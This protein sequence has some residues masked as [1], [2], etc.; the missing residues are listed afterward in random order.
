[1]A[2]SDDSPISD[3]RLVEILSELV[4]LR[5]TNERLVERIDELTERL[6]EQT[7]RIAELERENE[8]LRRTSKRPA[9]PFRRRDT[10]KKPKSQHKK[11]GR[12]SGHTGAS[13]ATPAPDEV[14]REHEVELSSCPCCGADELKNPH[15]LVQYVEDI[16]VRRVVH[17]ITTYSG[18]CE[19]C[20]RVRS[21]HPLQVSD[22]TGAA[23]VAVGPRAL[24]FALDLNKRLGLST[25]KT[26]EVLDQHLG[27]SLTAGGL[28][29]ASHRLAD[30]LEP[31]YE[32]LIDE[33]RDS[34]AVYVDETSWW[35]GEAGWWLWAFTDDEDTTVYSVEPRRNQKVV[36]EILGTD[37]TGV[38]GSDCLNI[39]D[40]LPY[41]QQKCYAHHL[42][43]LGRA[44]EQRPDSEFLARVRK[45][46]KIAM[47]MRDDEPMDEDLLGRFERW[48]RRLLGPRREDPVEEKLRNRLYKQ[49]EHLFTFLEF[50]EIAATN[51]AAERALR[52]AVVARKISCGN[53]TAQGSRTWEIIASLAR[54]CDQRDEDF[55]EL[56]QRAVKL[57]AQRPNAPPIERT[58]TY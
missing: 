40:G 45:L 51:N 4:K 53:R 9:A 50:P 6:Q 24:A 48:G 12:K 37:F 47:G 28:V 25:R 38:L 11:P 52:P 49:I 7:G 17:K 55:A 16:E 27:L 8:K 42:R 31:D 56:I 18:T 39:Y 20:G 41:E 26:C 10:A 58:A 46:L 30:R 29:G 15:P 21:R 22:A 43:A 1:M 3:D 5:R 33:L 36:H 2:M 32:A 13:R 44:L 23:G 19:T 14:D 35:V 34:A 57:R 54:S